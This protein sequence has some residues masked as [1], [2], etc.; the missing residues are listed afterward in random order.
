LKNSYIFWD[1]SHTILRV[2]RRERERGRGRAMVRVR[3][4]EKREH[5]DTVNKSSTNK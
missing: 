5:L 2:R 4:R 1:K 3:A